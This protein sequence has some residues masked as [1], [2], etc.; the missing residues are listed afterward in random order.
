MSLNISTSGGLQNI[1]IEA[2]HTAVSDRRPLLDENL[3]RVR[4]LASYQVDMIRMIILGHS[5]LKYQRL[6]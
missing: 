2:S 5:L 4:V 1:K 6:T 3:K